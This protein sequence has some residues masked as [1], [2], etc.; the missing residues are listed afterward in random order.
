MIK[1]FPWLHGSISS[2]EMGHEILRS[3]MRR[4]GESKGTKSKVEAPPIS[5]PFGRVNLEEEVTCF[6]AF[7]LLK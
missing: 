2:T 5:L 6:P 1:L 3:Q 4:H 7:A